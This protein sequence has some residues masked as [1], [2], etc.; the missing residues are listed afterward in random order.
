M[1]ILISYDSYFK[2]TKYL[3]AAMAESLEKCGVEVGLERIY[4]VD[5]DNLSDI[6]LLVIGAPTHHQ[7]MPR[8]IKSVLKHLPKGVLKGMKTLCYD[9]RY[10]M[11]IRRSGSAAKHID[12]LLRKLGGQTICPPE[13]FFVQERRGPLYP[14]EIERAQQW[15]VS[16]FD[17]V[18]DVQ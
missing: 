11:D 2:N 3:A 16:L 6:D 14:G 5:F 10:K 7:N 12:K 18:Q 13:S 9:T 1:N 8:P 15:V 4:Q 17:R